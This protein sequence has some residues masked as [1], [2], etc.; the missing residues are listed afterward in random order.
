MINSTLR[1]VQVMTT[2]TEVGRSSCPRHGATSVR[3][4][5]NKCV[6]VL[7]LHKRFAIII[8]FVEFL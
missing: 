5:E 7:Q 1:Y 2:N 6:V 3:I 8:T 4:K